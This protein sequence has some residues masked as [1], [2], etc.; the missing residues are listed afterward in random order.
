[1]NV[2]HNLNTLSPNFYFFTDLISTFMLKCP[3]CPLLFET[4]SSLCAHLRDDNYQLVCALC[5]KLFKTV[6]TRR[7]HFN[8]QHQPVEQLP[9]PICGKTFKHLFNLKAHENRVHAEKTILC[10]VCGKKFSRKCYLTEHCK[11]FH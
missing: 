8:S 7:I 10:V 3:H 4:K 1:M 2:L 9:C 5:D 6:V 11:K